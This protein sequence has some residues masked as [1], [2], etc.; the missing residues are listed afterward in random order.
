MTR[1]A[2]AKW[3]DGRLCDS[4]TAPAVAGG[5]EGSFFD[6]FTSPV[7]PGGFQESVFVDF[8]ADVLLRSV[9]VIRFEGSFDYVIGLPSN[10]VSLSFVTT[11]QGQETHRTLTGCPPGGGMLYFLSLQILCY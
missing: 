3:I 5:P 7:A 1:D 10:C 11:S 2:F 6:A 4:C 9:P 8:K